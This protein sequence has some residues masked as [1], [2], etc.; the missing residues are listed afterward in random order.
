MSIKELET[1][2]QNKISQKEK[3]TYHILLYMES[4][5]MILMNLF[6]GQQWRR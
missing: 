4:R 6:A 1:V 5:M 2:V 3:N